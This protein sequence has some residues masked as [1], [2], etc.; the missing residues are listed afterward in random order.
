MYRSGFCQDAGVKQEGER[1]WGSFPDFPQGMFPPECPPCIMALKVVAFLHA[2]LKATKSGESGRKFSLSC[3]CARP[4]RGHRLTGQGD[5][6]SCIRATQE[7]ESHF[8]EVIRNDQ[9]LT[10][11]LTV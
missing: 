10:L 6:S 3:A 8:E 7:R 2:P 4:Q 11:V 9:N 1:A 5:D